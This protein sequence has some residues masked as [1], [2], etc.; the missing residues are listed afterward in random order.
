MSP[1]SD[2]E[3]REKHE[4]KTRSKKKGNC[5]FHIDQKT[6]MRKPPQSSNVKDG[7]LSFVLR[8]RQ[9][10]VATMCVFIYQPQL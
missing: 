5:K 4:V 10:G 8:A 1:S 3:S 6:T 7:N 9:G 2:S